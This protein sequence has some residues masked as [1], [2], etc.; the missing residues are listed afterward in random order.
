MNLIIITLNKKL[1]YNPKNCLSKIV[2]YT[3]PGKAVV[4]IIHLIFV[5]LTAPNPK[6]LHHVGLKPESV[7]PDKEVVDQSTGS[8][9]SNDKS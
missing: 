4:G 1:K 7:I 2:Y 8:L 6:W 5:L 9:K 3:L